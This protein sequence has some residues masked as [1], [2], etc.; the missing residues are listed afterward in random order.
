[1][2]G[3]FKYI[4]VILLYVLAELGCVLKYQVKE[5]KNCS[6]ENTLLEKSKRLTRNLTQNQ[7]G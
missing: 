5:G 3:L 2:S 1:M 6:F 4:I 7:M